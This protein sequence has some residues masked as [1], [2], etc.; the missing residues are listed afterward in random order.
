MKEKTSNLHFIKKRKLT[1]HNWK[2][3]SR[4]LNKY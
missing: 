2:K 3:K 4:H 1:I